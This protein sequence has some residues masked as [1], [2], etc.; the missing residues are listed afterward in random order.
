MRGLLDQGR[1]DQ[2]VINRLEQNI[3]KEKIELVR[4]LKD[5]GITVKTAEAKLKAKDPSGSVVSTSNAE[6]EGSGVEEGSP[7]GTRRGTS[8]A[9]NPK[10]SSTKLSKG[11][12]GISDTEAEPTESFF[13]EMTPEE[14][15]EKLAY[16]R[17]EIDSFLSKVAPESP[18]LQHY[19]KKARVENGL[20]FEIDEL[21][22]VA[23][24]VNVTSEPELGLG[25]SYNPEYDIVVITGEGSP[26][27]DNEAMSIETK[28]L[29]LNDPV[30][31][32]EQ[33]EI[34]ENESRHYLN[35]SGTD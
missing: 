15:A 32:K 13:A 3:L 11:S 34:S 6:A 7:Q 22:D 9:S 5:Q 25:D 30:D 24:A 23:L 12:I 21:H 17:Q 27:I 2:E 10:A 4:L 26:V 20:M 19:L 1:Y 8:E 28:T 29:D 18:L 16:D 31:L 14:K 33:V 35:C